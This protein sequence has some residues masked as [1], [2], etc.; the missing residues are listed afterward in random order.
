MKADSRLG[1]SHGCASRRHSLC[2]LAVAATL[3]GL[4]ACGDPYLHTNPY[5]PV[6]PVAATITGPDTLFSQ[7]EI[8]QYSVQTNPA[9]PDTGIIWAID[10]FTD[11]FIVPGVPNACVVNQTASGD[12]VLP[13]NGTGVYTSVR[14]PLEPYSFSIA[15][16]VWLGAIDTTVGV[17]D[18]CAGG[19][20]AVQTRI[21]RH[22]VYKTVVVTQRL[23]RI[24]LRCPDTHACAPLAVGSTA[25]IWVD[26][27]DAL[28]H[29]IASLANSVANPATGNPTSPPYV[30]KDTAILR[31]QKGN[32]PIATYV[33]RDSTIARFTPVGIRVA[34]VTAVS[35]GTTWIVAT[36]GALAD[37]LQVVVH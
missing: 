1:S 25:D 35:S 28:G 27:F 36:R 14:P 21:P 15:I 29:Q 19:P 33:S 8:G 23:T 24:Q 4:V 16:E 3:V 22:I 9:W 18:P 32:N 34:H 26:G 12:T 13:G 30:T 5:D 31:V 7:G 11:Y 10:S 6:Y 37:S 2:A 20:H 17:Y